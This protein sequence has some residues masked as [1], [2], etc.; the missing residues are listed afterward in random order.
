MSARVLLSGVLF[1]PPASKVSKAGKPYAFATIREG[2]GQA[3]RWWKCFIFSE[4]AIE[5]VLRLGEGE[6]LAVSGEFDCELYTPPSGESRL[7]WRVT[8][9]AILSAR[10]KPNSKKGRQG[11]SRQGGA[12]EPPAAPNAGGA[13]D[14]SVPF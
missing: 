7:S 4:S 14:D 1:L 2:S 10:A 9:D 11:A 12:R 5:E 13:L 8:A 6:P 3:A